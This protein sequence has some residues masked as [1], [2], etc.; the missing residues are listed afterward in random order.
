MHDIDLACKEEINELITAAI[1]FPEDWEEFGSQ[2]FGVFRLWYRLSGY[3][4]EENSTIAAMRDYAET[5]W[6]SRGVNHG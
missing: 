4:D 6:R 1:D 5:I 3:V 2:A